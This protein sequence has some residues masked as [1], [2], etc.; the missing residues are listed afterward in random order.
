MIETRNERV[1]LL[2]AGLGNLLLTDDG[3]GIHALRALESDPPPGAVLLEI[4][5]AVLDALDW[6]ERADR[7][8]A[9]DAVHGAAEPGTV[10]RVDVGE[11]R[12]A[13]APMSIHELDLR[14]ALRL[15]PGARVPQIIALGVEPAVV[16][17]GME[18][19]PAVQAALPAYLEEIRALSAELLAAGA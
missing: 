19:S 7:I 2:I 11:L 12:P 3:V 6:I 9:L 10:Y 1:P 16:D 15:I 5:T 14:A 8:V 13:A 18:L 4:G 17:Y